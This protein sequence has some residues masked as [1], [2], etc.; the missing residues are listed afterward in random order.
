MLCSG[1][2]PAGKVVV[3][4]IQMLVAVNDDDKNGLK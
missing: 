3:A 4:S 2:T 1:T